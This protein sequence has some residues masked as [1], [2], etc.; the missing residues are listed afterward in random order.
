MLAN[1]KK[2]WGWLCLKSYLRWYWRRFKVV[3]VLPYCQ[4]PLWTYT[5][6]WTSVGQSRSWLCFRNPPQIW[7]ISLKHLK[8]PK[9][10]FKT[11]VFFLQLKYL[12]CTFTFGEK[13]K[14]WPPPPSY[15]KVHI[16]N[17]GLFYLR[18]WPPLQD[19]VALISK[20]IALS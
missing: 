9:N 3:L 1:I 19:L 20:P 17:C 11:N 15:Q 12:K 2:C 7:N 13:M 6:N 18:H 14:I 16:L 5:P 8:L 10:Q 4:T